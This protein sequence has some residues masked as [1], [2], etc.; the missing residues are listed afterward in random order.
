MIL[1][2]V[3]RGSIG[4]IARHVLH[5]V[6]LL[7]GTEHHLLISPLCELC[8]GS[9]VKIWVLLGDLSRGCV[10]RVSMEVE[11]LLLLIWILIE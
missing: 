3:V 11:S 10:R 2:K 1:R 6:R 4:S 5:L 9:G 7:L 8:V